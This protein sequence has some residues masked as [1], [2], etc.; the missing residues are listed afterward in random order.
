MSTVLL[1]CYTK[2]IFKL[3]SRILHYHSMLVLECLRI[4]SIQSIDQNLMKLGNS[5]VWGWVLFFFVFSL[6]TTSDEIS[7][8]LIP[9][10]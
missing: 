3:W 6:L 10:V 2:G 1:T 4:N 5:G 8:I 9:V 7:I